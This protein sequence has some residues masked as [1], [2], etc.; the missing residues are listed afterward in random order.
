[1]C[2]RPPLPLVCLR[3]P[4]AVAAVLNDASFLKLGKGAEEVDLQLK[5]REPAAMGSSPSRRLLASPSRRL[6][7]PSGGGGGGVDLV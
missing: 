5:L 1:M 2:L 7:S 6:L 3:A 4:D